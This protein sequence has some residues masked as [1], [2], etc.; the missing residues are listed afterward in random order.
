MTWD[1][2][3]LPPSSL[4]QLVQW[5]SR[6]SSKRGGNFLKVIKILNAEILTGV[7]QRKQKGKNH[8]A[9]FSKVEI[10]RW[11]LKT[12]MNKRDR[13]VVKTKVFIQHYQRSCRPKGPPLSPPTLNYLIPVSGWMRTTA[14]G[15]VSQAWGA[16]RSPGALVKGKPWLSKSEQRPEILLFFLFFHFWSVECKL[17]LWAY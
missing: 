2:Q 5:E 7:K 4:I 17:T 1:G 15:A 9:H 6:D 14:L 11:L 3:S 8:R 16:G 10:V 12:G 13:D